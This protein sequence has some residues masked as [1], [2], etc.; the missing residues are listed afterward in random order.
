MSWWSESIHSTILF[1]AVSQFNP[2]DPRNHGTKEGI[3]QAET[4]TI[5]SPQKLCI[6]SMYT[7]LTNL[8][9][10]TLF[11]AFPILGSTVIQTQSN[12]AWT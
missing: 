4:Y 10:C 7:F 6:A 1:D 11:Q 2:I 3:V 9:R 12:L 8:V 5:L